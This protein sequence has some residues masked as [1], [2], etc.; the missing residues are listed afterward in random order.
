MA[1]GN[2]P[3]GAD[4]SSLPTKMGDESSLLESIAAFIIQ[5]GDAAR[6]FLKTAQ[7]V[8]QPRLVIEQV[9][10]TVLLSVAIL[11]RLLAMTIARAERE[12]D[13]RKTHLRIGE[14]LGDLYDGVNMPTGFQRFI[15]HFVQAFDLKAAIMFTSNMLD[16]QSKG[17]WAAGIDQVW[18]QRYSDGLGDEDMLAQHVAAM[19]IAQFYASNLDL[20]PADFINTRFFRDW[21]APQNVACATGAILLRE[22][23]WLTQ[24]TLQRAP[25]QAP[26]SREELSHCNE[27]IPHLQRAIQMRQRFAELRAGQTLLTSGLNLIAMPTLLIDEFGRVAFAN[28]AAQVLLDQREHLL[29]D[30]AHLSTADRGIT[31]QLNFQIA[32]AIRASRGE[33]GGNPGVVLVPRPADQPLM[34]MVSPLR[35]SNGAS[36]SGAAL[37]IVY[38]PRQLRRATAPLISKLFGLTDAEANLSIALCSGRSLEEAAGERG[39]SLNTVRS[40]LKALF[41]KTGTNRQVDLITV[42]LSSPAYFLSCRKH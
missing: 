38:D 11:Q 16:Q 6:F 1:T 19:P 20:D 12:H 15:E 18:L 31:Q 36:A 17:L 42:L 22:G 33:A 27:L 37:I 9:R 34:L 24:I 26:F 21:V 29:C 35:L 25:S 4:R 41:I 30:A 13:Q 40:Q 10:A 39:T 3:V 23:A 32:S 28:D 7:H 14:L 5:I 8:R 2:F